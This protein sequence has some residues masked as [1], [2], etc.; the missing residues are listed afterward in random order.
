MYADIIDLHLE[1]ISLDRVSN[2]SQDFNELRRSISSIEMRTHPGRCMKFFVRH[3]LQ[4]LGLIELGS[5]VMNLGA[6]DDYY[7]LPRDLEERGQAL[8]HYTDMTVCIALQPFGWK[9]NGGKL[10][11][12]LATT[13]LDDYAETYQEELLG[14]YTMGAYG[15]PSQYERVYKFIGYT[16]GYTSFPVSEREYKQMKVWLISRDFDLPPKGATNVRWKTIKAYG[17]ATG[18]RISFKNGGVRA[19]YVAKNLYPRI[20]RQE[21]I[22]Y[23]YDKWGL[24][25]FHQKKNEECPHLA[26]QVSG[27]RRDVA[28]I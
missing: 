18:Q 13:I 15:R 17:K 25:R 19:I 1:Q 23:W 28:N 7:N 6:R 2:Q 22:K 21:R 16:K 14:L 8:R 24:P 4:I 26:V 5:P 12:E 20:K 11:A 9:W 27:E 3:G 10:L